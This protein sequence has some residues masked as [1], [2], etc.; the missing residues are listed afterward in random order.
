[1]SKKL[2]AVASAAALALTGLVVMPTVATADPGPFT[3]TVSGAVTSTADRN[4]TT[5]AK[6]YQ[7]EVPSS[8]VLRLVETA[9]HETGTV[10][11]I[12]IQTPGSTDA[13]TVTATGGVKVVT[14]SE[15]LEDLATA[16]GTQSL[17]D[18]AAN[19]AATIYAYNTS[20]TAATLVVSAAGSSQTIWLDGLTGPENAY[21]VSFT[22]PA[23]VGMG[24][25]F[26]V[27]GTVSD[28]FGNKIEEDVVVTVTGTGG[29]VEAEEELEWDSVKKV[30]AEDIDARTTAGQFALALSLDETATKVSAFGT[31][32]TTAFFVVNATDLSTQVT[33][34]TAQVTALQAQ[35][36]AS[37]PKATSVT[38]KKYNTLARKWNAANPGSR[39]ALKK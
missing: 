13:I 25:E 26:E 33:A 18:V 37:R 32:A 11:E 24:T 36:E 9:D 7:V 14:D 8:D 5:S 17:T 34:L 23:S 38:K 39:V 19:G 22:A 29:D 6:A 21:S 10:I 28:M 20:T 12:E 35:L 3:L 4:G 30:Y 2:I 31:P 1:M 27:S 15:D 16:D